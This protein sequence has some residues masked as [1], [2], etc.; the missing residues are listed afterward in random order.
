VADVI[1]F[2]YGINIIPSLKAGTVNPSLTVVASP[3]VTGASLRGA[4]V[5]V[6]LGERADVTQDVCFVSREAKNPNKRSKMGDY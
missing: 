1:F 2:F 6:A 5:R 4:A 3:R